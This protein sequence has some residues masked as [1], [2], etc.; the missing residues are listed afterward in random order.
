MKRILSE[1]VNNK[2]YT[3]TL[4]C[5]ALEPLLSSKEILVTLKLLENCNDQK[6]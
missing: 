2:H 5:L 3:K 1:T 6:L 4:G